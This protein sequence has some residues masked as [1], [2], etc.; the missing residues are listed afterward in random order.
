MAE[1]PDGSGIRGTWYLWKWHEGEIEN[2]SIVWWPLWGPRSLLLVCRAGPY[3]S[4]TPAENW[5]F[6]RQRREMHF[7]IERAYPAPS[8][9]SEERP[10]M[11]SRPQQLPETE[12]R[13][14]TR[15]PSWK[16]RT[17]HWK[18]DDNAAVPSDLKKM[19]SN[20]GSCAHM[21]SRV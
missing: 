19:T 20:L 10:R 12:H 18:L 11:K 9:R 21:T 3:P 16:Q 5:R 13:L 15:G 17:R 14:R 1:P 2:W 8:M 6:I 7:Q 4:S